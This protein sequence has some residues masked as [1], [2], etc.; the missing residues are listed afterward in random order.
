[1]AT[2]TK[3]PADVGVQVEKNTKDI[4]GLQARVGRIYTLTLYI[5]STSELKFKSA[6]DSIGEGGSRQS[7]K[8]FG[9][10]N[11]ALMDGVLVIASA[12]TCTWTGEG[13]LSA[14]VDASGVVTVTLQQNAYDFIT[15]ISAQPID[16]E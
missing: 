9:A 8:I 6:F 16:I 12:G 5:N 1:M 4:A 10:C 14:T 2:G 7:V 13:K 15:F 3:Y 11:S